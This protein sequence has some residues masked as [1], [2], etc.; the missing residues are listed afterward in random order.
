MYSNIKYRRD[1]ISRNIMNIYSYIRAICNESGTTRSRFSIR[2]LLL[3]LL[4]DGWFQY[5]QLH[6][7]YSW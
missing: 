6:D 4:G 3:Y 5:Y 7:I 2:N 1:Y